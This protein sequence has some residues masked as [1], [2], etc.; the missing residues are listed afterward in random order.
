MEDMVVRLAAFHRDFITRYTTITT[1]TPP[2]T[3][4]ATATVTV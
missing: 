3:A 1:I 4:T 2:A